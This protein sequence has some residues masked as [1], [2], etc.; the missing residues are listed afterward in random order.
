MKKYSFTFIG[1]AKCLRVSR[2]PARVFD[3]F[4]LLVYEIQTA[5]YPD[6]SAALLLSAYYDL[7]RARNSPHKWFRFKI[8]TLSSVGLNFISSVSGRVTAKFEWT[9]KF[10]PSLACYVFEI[11]LAKLTNEYL[12]LL[13]LQL[14]LKQFCKTTF[15][16]IAKGT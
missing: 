16:V 8:W 9:I 1:T 13:A 15:V 14:L 2:K 7:T 10:G 11:Q 4:T 5:V 3:D 12:V 6:S